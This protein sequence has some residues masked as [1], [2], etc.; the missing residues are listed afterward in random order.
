MFSRVSTRPDV[1][2]A[3]A[4]MVRW[5]ALFGPAGK[6]WSPGWG[7]YRIWEP[8]KLAWNENLDRMYGTFD[9]SGMKSSER[10]RNPGGK[11]KGQSTKGCDRGWMKA[12]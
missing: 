9:I 2:L 12:G 10:G 11:D 1:R 3:V 8:G 7:R 5:R 4:V 6:L